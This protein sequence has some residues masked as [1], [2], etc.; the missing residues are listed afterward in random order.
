MK[1]I[2]NYLIKGLLYFII[3]TTIEILIILTLIYFGI[4]YFGM[5]TDNFLQ[6]FAGVV[7]YF[8]LSIVMY[9][10]MLYF[11]L[12]VVFSLKTNINLQ[13]LNALLS[14]FLFFS[15]VFYFS[16]NLSTMINPI[17][18]MVI[19]SI[20]IIYFLKPINFFNRPV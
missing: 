19:S 8:G 4:P 3:Q 10:S 14:I 9:L 20:I 12:F 16:R 13:I 18:S 7:V 1:K 15:S 5:G 17:I 6:V 11:V 2:L